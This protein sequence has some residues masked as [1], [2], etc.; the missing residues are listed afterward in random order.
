MKSK[1]AVTICSLLELGPLTN[2]TM[3]IIINEIWLSNDVGTKYRLV[4]KWGRDGGN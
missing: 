4:K 1:L 2:A 3:D